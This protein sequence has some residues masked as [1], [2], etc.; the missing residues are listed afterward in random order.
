M[1]IGIVIILTLVVAL[2]L[3]MRA[4][5]VIHLTDKD[6][7]YIP[8]IKDIMISSIGEVLMKHKFDS[9]DLWEKDQYNN[10]IYNREKLIILLYKAMGELKKEKRMVFKGKC[11]DN[12]IFFIPFSK[13]PEKEKF[14]CR[15][16]VL[17]LKGSKCLGMS[18]TTGYDYQCRNC[19]KINDTGPTDGWYYL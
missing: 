14:V 19:G 7:S 16:C 6:L 13:K 8:E 1:V 9:I 15:K 12:N 11:N 4:N 2:Y 17:S 18:E 10:I 3:D 5:N